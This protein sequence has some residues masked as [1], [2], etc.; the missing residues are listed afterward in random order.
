MKRRGT[1][2]MPCSIAKAVDVVGDPWTM[3]VMRDALLGVSRFDDFVRRLDI[4]RATLSARL[5][6]LCERGVLQ[7]VDDRYVATAKGHDLMPVVITLM[8]WGDRWERDDP[9]PTRM[10]DGRDGRLLDPVLVDR[11]T[12]TPLM[13]LAVRAE[14]PVTDG[15]R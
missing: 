7:R 14:G 12:G 8:Q 2:D 9:P 1:A 4:P 13:D 10:V 3:L 5:T 6:H 15:I 11:G